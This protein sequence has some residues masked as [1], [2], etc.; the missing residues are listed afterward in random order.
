MADRLA[1]VAAV[2]LLTAL[3]QCAG[4]APAHAV[5]PPPI[6][7]HLLP[8]AAPPGPPRATR[9][10]EVCQVPGFDQ[11][12]AA[13]P[14]QL[15]S[16]GLAA[17]WPLTR[18]AGQRVAVIDTGVAPHRRLPQLV[19]GGDYVFTG[20]GTQDCDGHGTLVAGI[21]AAA[22]DPGADRFSGVAPQ[23]AVIAIRQSSTRFG[24]AD[25]PSRSGVGDVET[26]AKA[27]R[28][29]ADLGASVITISAVACEPAGS[30]L[31]DRA[32]GAALA[33]AVDVRNAVVVAAAGNTGD[34]QRCPAQGAH[35]GPGEATVVVS[36]AWYDDYVLTVGSVD[37]AGAPSAFTLPSPW[38]DVAAPGEAVLSLS[39]VGDAVANTAGPEQGSDP[40]VGTSYAAPV[41]SGLVA[42][43]RSRFPSWTPRQVMDRIKATAHH[44]PGGRD[45]FVGSGVI[46]P[47]AAVS[48]DAPLATSTAVPD[49]VALPLPPPP[50]PPAE[51]GG[52]RTALAG[53]AALGA[54]L[55]AL[56][57]G[58][59]LR[60]PGAGDAAGVDNVAG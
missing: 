7:D 31:D 32:L 46:D 30:G 11:G 56:L 29:A 13:A 53:V 28:T 23:A 2:A 40:I 18:G 21:V 16:L 36:P 12:R 59:R 44:P 33:Y 25:D 10:R 52:R 57:A 19:G 35:T 6:D 4:A 50:A 49:A 27:V 54:V 58:R 3:S 48:A 38:V 17:V 20:D 43:I 9:Q 34:A 51:A 60:R 15:D 37:T 26:L 55:V 24:A 5:G 1:R 39:P 42:L 14:S 45:G 47:L 41:V 22:A 8:A